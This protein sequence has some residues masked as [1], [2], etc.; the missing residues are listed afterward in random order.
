MRLFPWTTLSAAIVGDD[1]VTAVIARGVFGASVRRG[2]VLRRFLAMPADE[3]RRALAAI[4]PGSGTRLILTVPTSWC[5]VRPVPMD[6][7]GWGAAREGVLASIEQLVPVSSS[8]AMVGLV[9]RRPG[10]TPGASS[11]AVGD[12]SEETAS[13]ASGWLIVA[14]RPQVVAWIEALSRAAGRS[15]SA[16]LAAPMAVLGLGLQNADRAEVLDELAG[17]VGVR[18]TLVGG[19][20]DELTGS[21]GLSD[22]PSA[23]AVRMPGADAEIGGTPLSAHDLAVAAALAEEIGA[24]AFVPLE[25]RSTRAPNRWLVPAAAAV[26]AGLLWVGA[27]RVS[28]WRSEQAIIALEDER[29]VFASELKEVEAARS[30]TLRLASLIDSGINPVVKSWT[31]ALPALASAQAAVP[32]DGFL[33][34]VKTTTDGVEMRGEAKQAADVLR[35]LASETGP[36]VNV[37]QVDPISPVPQR[38][39][40]TFTFSAKRKPAAPDPAAKSA[41][42]GES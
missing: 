1:L 4:D 6:V 25:G 38:G 2:P 40:E 17:R 36:F 28:D 13:A 26:V 9:S 23:G 29:A 35:A 12:G 34:W 41:K 18:H 11:S 30:E 3:A 27:G 21:M 10:S 15:P 7:R 20:I 31:P 33:Y 16:V 5:S 22:V 14:R 37:R 19:E 32:V 39:L 8:E 24:G 42:G